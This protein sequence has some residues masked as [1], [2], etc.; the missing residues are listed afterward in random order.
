MLIRAELPVIAN[1]NQARS[2][3]VLW[4]KNRNVVTARGQKLINWSRCHA[5]H[6]INFHVQFQLSTSLYAMKYNTS[7]SPTAIRLKKCNAIFVP[8]SNQARI[9]NYD[10]C[11]LIL[12]LFT[13]V[14]ASFS[15]QKQKTQTAH[16]GGFSEE[17]NPPFWC[18][19]AQSILLRILS[20]SKYFKNL[21]IRFGSCPNTL[22]PAE[23]GVKKGWADPNSIN[24][25]ELIQTPHSITKIDFPIFRPLNLKC[26]MLQLSNGLKGETLT[27]LDGMFCIWELQTITL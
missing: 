2:K 14:V 1:N 5:S 25:L 16:I 21:R 22:F 24:R 27:M 3:A 19:D 20:S 23:P 12:M 18:A 10:E 8:N 26:K 15:T 9:E 4:K 6:E 7:K 11:A 17:R 13:K